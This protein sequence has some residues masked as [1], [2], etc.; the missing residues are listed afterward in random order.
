MPPNSDALPELVI[1]DE[2]DSATARRIRRLAAAGRL[3]RLYA[4]VYSSNLDAPP[5]SIV[6]RHWRPIVGYLL[7]GGI[8]SHR[9]AFDGRPHEGSLSIT[10]GKTRRSLKLPGLTVQVLPGEGP[11]LAPPMSDTPYG[12]LFLAS[13][14]RRYLENLTRGRGWSV[15]VLPQEAIEA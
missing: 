2:G 10:R 12:A 9:S 6:V 8:V 5:E 15:H 3:R 1:V 11:R 4:G 7:A 14:P 13:D